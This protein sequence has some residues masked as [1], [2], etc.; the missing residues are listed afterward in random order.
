MTKIITNQHFTGERALFK[1]KD[2]KLVDCLLDDGESH[3]KESCDVTAEN[4]IFGWKYPLWYGNNLT[5]EGGKLLPEA[6]AAI[7][8]STNVKFD[9]VEILAPKAFRRA[10]DVTLTNVRFTDA[11][12]TLWGCSYVKLIDV[13]AA[14]NY[15]AMNCSGVAAYNLTIDGN[16]CFDGAKNVT[17]HD[18]VLN[19]KD[20]FWNCDNVTV[21]DTVIKG[22][23]LGWNSRNLTF[24]NCT[25]NSL[26]GLCYVEGLKLVNCRLADTN[27][28]FEYCS[29][30]AADIVGNVVSV[31]NPLSGKI[32]ADGYGEIILDD[33]DVD[34]TK[35]Q[36]SVRG[37]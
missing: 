9:N 27:L 17:L 11:A 10:K 24:V 15:F 31:K 35:T 25:I 16:Y 19:S 5:V 37:K 29:N 6:R 32:V 12:E 18:C 33:N 7:W 1:S 2:I 23:Y 36:I 14:G 20:S 21:Y 13:Y 3:I 26:Q 34:H 30:I 4:C 22:E 8:Y 28:C